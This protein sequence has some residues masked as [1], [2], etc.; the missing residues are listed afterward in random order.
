MGR[1]G[2][3]LGV[4]LIEPWPIAGREH[5]FEGMRGAGR[6][7]RL[8]ALGHARSRVSIIGPRLSMLGMVPEPP[9]RP[10]NASGARA[11]RRRWMLIAAATFL[12]GAAG[13]ATAAVLWHSSVQARER[14]SFQTSATDVTGTLEVLLRRDTDFVRAVRAVLALQPELSPSGF[15][16]WFERLE[17]P[18]VQS[19]AYGALVVRSV[20]APRLAAF[21][22]RR[23]G[24]GAFRRL[25]GGAVEPVPV[26]GRSHYCLLA[27]G[28]AELGASVELRS[29]LQGDWCDPN[30]LIGGYRQNGTT[31]A[32]FTQAIT[33]SGE[34]AVYSAE[35]APE[36]SSL[37][38]E[39]AVFRR[40]AAIATAAER[41]AAVVGWVLGSFDIPSLMRSALGGHRRL[42]VTLYHRNGRL[43]A[44][45]I[46]ALGASAGAEPFAHGATLAVDGTWIIEV[47]GSASTGGP[48]AGYQALAVLLGGLLASVLL[49][50]LIV[51]LARSRDRALRTAQEK[52]GELAHLAL[53]DPLTG[54]PNRIVALDRA[55]QML[56]R[57]RRVHQP[58][59]ALSVDLDGFKQVNDSLGHAAGDELLRCVA[60]RLAS[61]VRGGDTAA[62]LGGDE[63]VV[64]VEGSTLDVGPELVAERLLE[65]LREPYEIR[66][67]ARPLSLTASI[68]ISVGLDLDAEQLLRE[69]DIALYEAQS[70]GRNRHVVYRSG[71]ETAIQDRLTLQMD[72]ADALE[73]DQFFLAYQPILDL[74]SGRPVAAEAL[75]RWRHPGRGLVAPLDFIP[76]AETS[77]MITAIGRWVLHEACAQAAGWRRSGHDV[78]ISVNVSPRQLEDAGLLEDVYCALDDSGLD[79]TA[80]TL[81]VTETALMRDPRGISER[82]QTLRALGV[83]VAVDDFGTGYSSLA[84]LR[85]LPADCL[86]IDRSFV[87]GMASS[88]RAR[89][90]VRM[91][92]QLGRALSV[93][94]IAEGIEDDAQRDALRRD[95]CDR[96]QG[97]LFARPLDAEQIDAFL[98][99]AQS[100]PPSRSR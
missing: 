51:V 79:P 66:S 23:D 3:L 78:G 76:I 36:V 14:Q 83:R 19:G 43:P 98:A 46:G 89:S 64:L 21:Q 68:G 15:R 35:V 82:L 73:Q 9:T 86:K 71:M 40:H 25:V 27:G 97:Y 87:S 18:Q 22:A 32:Q 48:S 55:E 41:R 24:D 37:V 4:E 99:G 44:E 47:T 80:L 70:A 57:S 56:A 94:T 67:S 53:H 34:Y 12:I 95:G 90:L 7:A 33:E 16:E 20:P 77:G 28:S 10:A 81:E 29:V 88:A 100:A 69:A 85:E 30:S 31:R 49:S 74:A 50:A 2:A 54:L 91:L 60:T 58:V 63:F 5:V 92:V 38:L 45:F 59:A 39:A 26:T 72:L 75:L 62:R 65:L 96:G 6:A 42:G 13:S 84:H 61:V 52:T 17:D 93:E 11:G 8:L 1:R